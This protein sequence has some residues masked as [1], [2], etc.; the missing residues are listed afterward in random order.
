MPSF[1]NPLMICTLEIL[2]TMFY[3]SKVSPLEEQRFRKQLVMS[4]NPSVN[5]VWTILNIFSIKQ[6]RNIVDRLYS[7]LAV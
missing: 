2:P 1:V 5:W 6:N 3:L 7:A 4:Q